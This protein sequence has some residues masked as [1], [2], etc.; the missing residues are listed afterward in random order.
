[1]KFFPII[2]LLFFA[3]CSKNKT[4]PQKPSEAVFEISKKRKFYE[5]KMKEKNFKLE[6]TGDCDDALSDTLHERNVAYIVNKEISDSLVIIDFKF[7]EACCQEY[8][9]DYSIS[10]DTLI[11]KYEQVNE[12]VC[13][14]ICWYKYSLLINHPKFKIKNIK[15]VPIE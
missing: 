12:G 11:F 5:A 3:S 9:G 8:L 6:L 15:L 4:E 14:C 13:A 10:N 7:K 1:M 2:I